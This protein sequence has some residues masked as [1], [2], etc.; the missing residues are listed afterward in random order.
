MNDALENMVAGDAHYK[1]FVGPPLKYDLL[2]ALQFTLLTASGLLAK[3]RLCDIGC[4]SLRGGKMLIPYLNSGNYF[5]LEPNE[6]LVKEG[7]DKELSAGLVALKEPSFTHNFDFNLNAFAGR[8]DFLIAQSI[9]SHASASQVHQCLKSAKAKMKPQSL[10]LTTFVEGKEDYQGQE[11]VYPGCVEFS[12]QGIQKM[13]KDCG[14]VATRTN[15]PHP[16]NQTWYLIHFTENQTEA[17]QKALF[18][19][20]AYAFTPPPSAPE[21][22]FKEKVVYNLKLRLGLLKK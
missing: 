8:F 9:F 14:L 12:P 17:S 7:I 4:G 6:W 10:F 18:S 2:G 19:L 22:S 3:H 21:P 1:A 15:W 5:G 13:A 11:W 16:N 20:E